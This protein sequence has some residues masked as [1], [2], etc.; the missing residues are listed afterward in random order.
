MNEIRQELLNSI[1]ENVLPLYWET[2]QNI[3]MNKSESFSDQHKRCNQRK[4][5]SNSG[6]MRLCLALPSSKR[7]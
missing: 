1:G 5:L 4:L 3:I 6:T 2:I 7:N